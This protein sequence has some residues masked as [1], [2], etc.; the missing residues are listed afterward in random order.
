LQPNPV[1]GEQPP[2][3][4]QL[5]AAQ[6]TYDAAAATAAAADAAYDAAVAAE[7]DALLVASGGRALSDAALAE[8]RANLGL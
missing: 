5:A 8:Y 7:N 6:T 4:S 1:P 3:I 2:E